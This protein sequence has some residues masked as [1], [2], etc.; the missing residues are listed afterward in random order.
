MDYENWQLIIM[1][2]DKIENKTNLF[3]FGDIKIKLLNLFG[4]KLGVKVR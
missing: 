3:T 1:D 2:E 4:K